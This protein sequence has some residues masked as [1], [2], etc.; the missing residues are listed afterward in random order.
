MSPRV[1]FLLPLAAALGLCAPPAWAGYDPALRALLLQGERHNYEGDFDAAD[2][3][4]RRIRALDPE[5]PAA[6]LYEVSTL[7]W[8]LSLDDDDTR[9]DDAIRG[10]S[11]EAAR[12]AEA[13]VQRDPADAV[14]HLFWGQALMQLGRLLGTRGEYLR[15]GSTAERGRE[16]LE[17]ALALEPGLV[18]AKAPIGMYY[19]Y[20]STVPDALRWLSFLWFVPSGDRDTGLRYLR[21]AAE[22]GDVMRREAR[23]VLLNVYT[24]HQQ[25]LEQALGLARDFAER[26]PRN[27]FFRFEEL[28]ILLMLKRPQDAVRAALALEAGTGG[29]PQDEGRRTMA[30]VWRAQ[31]ELQGGA[32]ARAWEILE[33]LGAG[34][35]WPWWGRAWV[36]LT[37][38]RV[39]DLCGDRSRALALYR[40]VESLEGARRSKR[41]ARA[42]LAGLREPFQLAG[43]G[44]ASLHAPG[45]QQAMCSGLAPGVAAGTAGG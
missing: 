9:Y 36:L 11:Q 12:L 29:S 37:R 24:Y 20:A 18:D 4:W 32:P 39:L 3:V 2:A 44:E 31:A 45:D 10:K 16:H 42:A 5:S 28:E 35:G 38:G 19:F 43:P 33:P 23:F 27:S 8:R 26:F 1:R 13:R 34:P 25:D 21:E 41:A 15:A 7:W 6:P 22:E 40:E 17:R 30:R 14:A